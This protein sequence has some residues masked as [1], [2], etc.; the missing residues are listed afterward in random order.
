M[1]RWNERGAAFFVGSVALALALASCGGR[2]SSLQPTGSLNGNGGATRGG[3]TGIDGGALIGGGAGSS[4]SDAAAGNGAASGTSGVPASDG[5]FPV[6]SD[7]CP[8]LNCPLGQTLQYPDTLCCPICES[9]S[10]PDQ[11]CPPA[12]DC[13]PAA[14]LEIPAAQCCAECVANDQAACTSQVQTVNA[15]VSAL[16]QLRGAC[17]KDSDCASALVDS[18]CARVCIYD[19]KDRVAAYA[20]Q[21]TQ[22][23]DC[24]ACP[25]PPPA[26]PTCLTPVCWRGSCGDSI[27]LD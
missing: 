6:C 15:A 19:L 1:V 27:P 25:L 11:R 16:N 22:V 13:G 5:G 24:S 4:G 17:Q 10:A 3:G 8:E 7:P 9:C 20:A 26:P 21:L 14:H 23:E 18:T 12:A 2:A